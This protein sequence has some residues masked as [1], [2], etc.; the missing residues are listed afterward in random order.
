MYTEFCLHFSILLI[1]LRDKGQE[2]LGCL[3]KVR[4]LKRGR[5]GARM[6]GSRLSSNVLVPVFTL[7]SRHSFVRQTEQ[8]YYYHDLIVEERNQVSERKSH[9]F[10]VTHSLSGKAGFD[11]ALSV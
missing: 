7:V 1:L 6:V 11:P 10:K 9:L 4:P 8:F 5:A 3:F 2:K